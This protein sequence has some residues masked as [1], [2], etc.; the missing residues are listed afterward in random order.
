MYRNTPRRGTGRTPSEMMFGRQARTIFDQLKP[1]VHRRL[2]QETLKQKANFDKHRVKDKFF[3]VKDPV[4]INNQLSRGS[5]AGNILKQS[6]PYSYLVEVN[7]SVKRKHADQIRH[8]YMEPDE[9]ETHTRDPDIEH[10]SN[11]PSDEMCHTLRDITLESTPVNPTPVKTPEPPTTE[12][13]PV[14]PKEVSEKRYPSRSRQMPIRYR[15]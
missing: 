5:T 10:T 8:R 3:Q 9:V 1:D 14:K 2:D 6:G 4:W 11:K 7:G 12:L 15:Q 13:T